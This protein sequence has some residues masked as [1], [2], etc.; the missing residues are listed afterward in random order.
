[1]KAKSIAEGQGEQVSYEKFTYWCS[2]SK[3]ELKAAIAD[4]KETID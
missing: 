2:T 3:A 1:L 4:A